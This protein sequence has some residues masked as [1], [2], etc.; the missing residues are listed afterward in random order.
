MDKFLYC[1]NPAVFLKAAQYLDAAPEECTVVEDAV[2]GAQ[3]GK[4]ARMQV[5]CVGDASKEKAG[6]D[7]INSFGELLGILP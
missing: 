5:V 2:S 3:A 6:D 1:I 7:N 4:A